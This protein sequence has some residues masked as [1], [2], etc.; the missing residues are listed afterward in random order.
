MAARLAVRRLGTQVVR[1]AI[2]RRAMS[3]FAGWEN[4]DL[5]PAALQAMYNETWPNAIGDFEVRDPATRQVIATLKSCGIAETQ[6]AVRVAHE[7]FERAGYAV[8]ANAAH[9]R[10]TRLLK[11]HDLILENVTDLAA[12]ATIENG[13]PRAEAHNEV[14]SGAQSVAWFA[15]EARRIDGDLLPGAGGQRAVILRQPVG[16]VG[17]ITPWNFPF[18][19]ITRKVSPA[20]AAGCPVVLK[21]SEETPL[22]AIALLR[23]ARDAGFGPG[24]VQVLCGDAPGIGLAFSEMKEVR[25]IGFTGSTRVGKLLMRQASDSVKRL[26]FELGGNAP[27]LVFEDADLAKAAAMA[28]ASGM[29]NAGQTCICADRI[30]VQESVHDRFVELLQVQ[31]A[32]LQI[33]HGLAKGTTQGPL[34]NEASFSKVQAHVDDARVK[35]ATVV[36]GGQRAHPGTEDGSGV[37]EGFFFEPTLLTGVTES[38]QCFDEENFGPIMAVRS[39][40]DE[41]EAIA[42]ANATEHG[43]AAY[44][45]TADGARQWRLGEQLAFGMVGINR[46]D[47][48]GVTS[49]FG[50]WKQS[51]LGLEHS[52]YGIDEF[53]QKKA[54]Y[55]NV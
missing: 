28:A 21:P 51:G 33:G 26:S 25:K 9:E 16:V 27:F 15:E 48:V 22:S 10:R 23:L 55:M 38:M 30:L 54:V 19:M 43:L 44:A 8:S 1:R 3:S 36:M 14:L 4:D 13:K 17:A 34:I 52:K 2:A 20:L 12:L 29:R 42:I 31:L 32:K 39:F 47:V 41:K 11:W 50:G 35:G 46:V 5:S 45:F 53:L 37:L 49:P 24:D 18:S 40:R 7:A 6:E